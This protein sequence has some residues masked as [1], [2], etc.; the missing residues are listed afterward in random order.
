MPR[1]GDS[2]EAERGRKDPYPFTP[3][4][5]KV[6]LSFSEPR[7]ERLASVYVTMLK[8]KDLGDCKIDCALRHSDFPKLLNKGKCSRTSMAFTYD[9]EIWERLATLEVAGC[10]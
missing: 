9:T 8:T 4:Q 1:L 10:S 6:N 3:F 2:G 5:P 7:S